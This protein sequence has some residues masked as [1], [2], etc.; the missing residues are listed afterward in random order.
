MGFKI[1]HLWAVVDI[2]ANGDEGVV[3]IR[4]GDFLLPLVAVDETRVETLIPL[5]Q[6][7]ADATGERLKLIKFGIREDVREI[8]GLVDRGTS[9]Q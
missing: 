2:D 4:R 8:V 6:E 7:F 3:A 9:R 1:K 5:A